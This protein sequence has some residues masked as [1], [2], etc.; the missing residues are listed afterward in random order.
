[1]TIRPTHINQVLEAAAREFKPSH[2]NRQQAEQLCQEAFAQLSK[3]A[4]EA[5]RTVRKAC[6][7]L[8]GT[9]S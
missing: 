8:Y 6:A 9:V 2:P 5:Y 1:M 4:H 7:V 3:D